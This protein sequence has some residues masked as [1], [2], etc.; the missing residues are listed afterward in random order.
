VSHV[1]TRSERA[2]NV[3]RRVLDVAARLL[4]GLTI[5]AAVAAAAVS[6]AWLTWLADTPPNGADEW[7]SR[8]VVLGIALVP[9]GVL[10]LFVAGVRQLG[11][12][13]QRART[14]PADVRAK[15]TQLKDRSTRARGPLGALAALFRLARLV[16]GSR[17]VL[18][19]YA[20]VTAALRPA[21]LVAALL[22]T[23]AAVA[24][25]P[26]ALLVILLLLVT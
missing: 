25:V 6:A 26:G 13:S 21:I 18:S 10:L 4:R 14:L 7:V 12:L 9:T 15:A 1:T 3:L 8:F 17:E 2:A 23:L 16:F 5:L 19:P 24:E 22:A 20:A 11:E